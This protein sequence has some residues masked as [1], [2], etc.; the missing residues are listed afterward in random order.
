MQAQRFWHGIREQTDGYFSDAQPLWR[1]S[2]K[3]TTPPLDLPGSQLIEWGGALRWL[4]T[5]AAAQSIRAAA[6]RAGGHAT[7]FRDGDKTAGVFQPLSAPL[8]TI[9]QRLKQSFDPAGILN[10]GR[11]YAEF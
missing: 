11:M 10:P 4:K 5:D 7:L 1:L 3:S 8:M 9:H 2:V 6:T